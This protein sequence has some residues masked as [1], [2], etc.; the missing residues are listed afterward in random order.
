MLTCS[1]PH[2]DGLHLL[3]ISAFP[4]G[5]LP[6]LLLP[7]WAPWRTG[8]SA[9]IC[10]HTTVEEAVS[11]RTEKEVGQAGSEGQTRAPLAL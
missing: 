10:F 2:A 5:C 7:P 6:S 8:R 11:T 4:V 3:C 1:H 9:L